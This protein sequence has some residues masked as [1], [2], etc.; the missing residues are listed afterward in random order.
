M[1]TEQGIKT[2]LDAMKGFHGKFKKMYGQVALR[3]D[4]DSYLMSGG[5]KLLSAIQ[6]EDLSICDINSGDLGIIFRKRDDINAFIF[7][8]SSDTVDVSNE[9]DA[10]PVALED[11][12]QLSGSTVPIATDTTPGSLLVSLRNSNVCLIKGTG[13]VAI[14]KNAKGAVASLHILQ[15]SC[16]AY[17]HGKMLG[18]LK[19]LDENMA[20]WFKETYHNS[21]LETNDESHVNYVGYNE[22]RFNLRTQLVEFGTQ[23]IK[24]DLAYGN[25]GN[26]SV[27]S[28]VDENHMLITPSSMDYFEIGPE[29]TVLVD[30][31]TLE[32][33]DQRVPSTDAELHAE[34]YRKLPG[35]N[36]IIHT[37]S[38]A[39]S[40]FAACEAGFAM[41]DPSLQQLIGDVKNVPYTPEDQ[42][43]TMSNILATLSETHAAI[44]PH[45][46]A[47]FYGP[48]LDLVYEIAK[49]V[50]M[51]ARNLLQYDAKSVDDNEEA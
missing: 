50:E 14:S 30:L 37:H 15:K 33:G 16:E 45:H 7:G 22:D 43:L 8:C 24:D 42:E 26:L 27:R 47:I 48:S 28:T 35:C 31:D 20:T 49:A 51:M 17:A 34:M 19:P 29:D 21:Y 32:Y 3:L 40:V 6:A 46:G 5:N 1:T 18:G 39:C 4:E 38:N 36:A 2:L 41:T 23:L 12:A 25:G 11:M 13:A 9:V 44:L 10:L